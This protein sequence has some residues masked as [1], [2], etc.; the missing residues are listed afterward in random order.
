MSKCFL[1]AYKY[2][3]MGMSATHHFSCQSFAGLYTV[4]DGFT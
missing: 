4:V 3:D 1:L 2:S